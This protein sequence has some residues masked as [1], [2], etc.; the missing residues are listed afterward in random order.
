M[1]TPKALFVH[2]MFSRIAPYYDLMNRLISF[3]LDQKWRQ[4]MAQG[5]PNAGLI[6]DLAA[7]TGDST[8]ALLK[9]KRGAKVVALDFCEEMLKRAK[10]KLGKFEGRFALVQGDALDLPFADKSF[11]GVISAFAM[12]NLSD[13]RAALREI[14]RVIKPEGFFICLEI[15]SPPEPL[16]FAFNFYF[17]RLV[18]FMGKIVARNPEAYNY[19][20]Q[21]V[22]QFVTPVEFAGLM[23]E[24]GFKEVK[25]RRL[26]PWAVVLHRGFKP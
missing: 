9:A 17:G 5:V 10:P 13:L 4:E 23:E 24:A 20:P 12:R 8:L 11:D 21:S 14:F 2:S 25:F 15:S 3:S 22:A 1:Q 18:P 6:L 16:R 19:L 7:G 26:F